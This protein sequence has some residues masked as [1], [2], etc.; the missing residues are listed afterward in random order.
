[1]VY[2]I[3]KR[4]KKH[5]DRGL[6]PVLKSAYRLGLRPTHITLLSIPV[7]VAGVLLM[8]ENPLFGAPLVLSYVVLDVLDGSLARV[9]DSVTA[10]GDRLDFVGDRLVATL[11]LINYLIH[12]GSRLFG[13]TGLVAVLAI[14][15]ED[16]GYIRK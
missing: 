14:T 16:L 5:I 11:F 6:S 10:S 8:Y 4:I 12:D 3:L 9:T 13:I 7:G 1:M 2:R 15:A